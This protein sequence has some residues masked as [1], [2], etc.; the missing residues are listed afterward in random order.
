M[1][2]QANSGA[3]VVKN[4]PHRRNALQ[5]NVVSCSE[6]K[7]ESVT[8]NFPG[9]RATVKE[10]NRSLKQL[11]SVLKLSDVENISHVLRCLVHKF[12]QFFETQTKSRSI[13]PHCSRRFSV[14]RF[15][16]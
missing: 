10:R 6:I 9:D 1:S 2:S 3:S 14:F 13:N 15:Q 4:I 11:H 12:A 5:V 7:K 16:L 8:G